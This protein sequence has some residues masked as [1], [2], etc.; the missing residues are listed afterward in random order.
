[1]E[2]VYKKEKMEKLALNKENFDQILLMLNSSDKE[3]VVMGLICIEELDVKTGL[4]YLL[5]IRKLANVTDEL[6]KMHA[7]TKVTA[8]KNMGIN[9]GTVLTYKKILDLL[10]SRKVPTDDIEFYLSK[11]G[12][13]LNSTLHSLG[14]DVIE[15]VEIKLKI[16]LH[17]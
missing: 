12:E 13:Y 2:N 10:T 6:W 16:K 8:L 11:F 7:P 4:A 5:L 17:D 15:A 3:N 1:M 14:Y 9:S